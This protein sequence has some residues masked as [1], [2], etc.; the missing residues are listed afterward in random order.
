[1][2]V[3]MLIELEATDLAD[4]QTVL[5]CYVNLMKDRRTNFADDRAARVQAVADR[6]LLARLH[7]CR[8]VA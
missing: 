8:E 2:T 7:D 5:K 6:L 3:K 1:M 4:I